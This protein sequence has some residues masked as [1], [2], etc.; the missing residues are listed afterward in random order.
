MPLTESD[1]AQLFR[2]EPDGFL[3]IGAGEVAH[4]KVGSGPDVLFVHGWPVSGATWRKLLPHLV[5]HVTCHVI[6]LPSAGSSRFD[7]GTPMSIQQH[8]TS[9]QRVVDLLGFDKI[10]VV[11]H[12]SGGMIA[13]HAM[14]GDQRLRSMGLINTE[15]PNPS[16]RF[17]SFI[18]ARRLP[19]FSA[20]LGWVAGQPKIR[21][22]KLV[23]GDAFADRALL[24]GEFAEFFFHPLHNNT[25]ARDAAVRLLRSF[26]MSH[27]TGLLATHRQLDV[28]VK[29][30]W[31]DRDPFFPADR[32][33]AMVST[34][35]NASIDIIEGAGLF[36]HEEAPTDVATSLLP[37]LTIP[38]QD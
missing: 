35:P 4:R 32:A 26:D 10:A 36:S 5:D 24:D 17:R 30:V 1:A 19:G 12:N 29:L 9:V 11:G 33:K 15:P 2:E 8:I 23:F 28:P 38:P 14:A 21:A 34:F 16:W 13:R 31:G 18:A 27:V 22:S 20:G 7:A 25:I 6:D 3:D 37:T